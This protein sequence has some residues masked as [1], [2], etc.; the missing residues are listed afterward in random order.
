MSD[1]QPILDRILNDAAEEARTIV[2]E[3]QARADERVAAAKTAAEQTV[4]DANARARRDTDDLI[5]R[6]RTV[7]ALEVKKIALESRRNVLDGAF[8]RA[9]QKLTQMSATEYGDFLAKLLDKYAEYEDEIVL[10]EKC[11]VERSFIMALPSY[12]NKKLRLSRYGGNF[13]GGL[14]LV[15]KN[16]DKSLTFETLIAEARSRIE[17]QVAAELEG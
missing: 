11:P 15:G 13:A 3:A 5:A 10:A 14:I 12:E 6:R 16:Y 4:A 9:L 1:T 17:T 7:A 8:D 2:A